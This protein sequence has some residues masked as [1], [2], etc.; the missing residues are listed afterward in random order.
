MTRCSRKAPGLTRPPKE[1][2]THSQAPKRRNLWEEIRRF[3]VQVP[4]YGTQKY[5]PWHLPHHRLTSAA[6]PVAFPRSSSKSS[7]TAREWFF[8]LGLPRLG[9][10][11]CRLPVMLLAKFSPWTVPGGSDPWVFSVQRPVRFSTFGAPPGKSLPCPST[12]FRINVRAPSVPKLT[13]IEFPDAP[14]HAHL[15]KNRSPVKAHR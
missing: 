8:V 9:T 2:S 12:S 7:W 6:D 1:V 3:D 15:P 11:F 14:E 4:V 5:V 13:A 10:S